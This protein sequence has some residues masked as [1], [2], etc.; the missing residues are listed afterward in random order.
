MAIQ[1]LIEE[2]LRTSVRI[3]LAD[4]R[5]MILPWHIIDCEY[6]RCCQFHPMWCVTKEKKKHRMTW[7]PLDWFWLVHWSKTGRILKHASILAFPQASH[8][9]LV[10]LVGW[11]FRAFIPIR[12][13]ASVPP[14][15]SWRLWDPHSA[16][17]GHVECS[18]CSI[19]GSL[20]WNPSAGTG[21]LPFYWTD[22]N[23]PS[24]DVGLLFSSW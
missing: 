10:R 23:A 20:E 6:H 4:T 14:S 19:L 16:P 7:A 12:H 9:R 11:R 13:S 22:C 2:V 17:L 24:M 1:G 15:Q 3:S 5:R 18:Y 8:N 21:S